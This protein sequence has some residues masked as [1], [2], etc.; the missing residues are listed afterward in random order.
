MKGESGFRRRQCKGQR[1]T[2]VAVRRGEISRHAQQAVERRSH[3]MPS[4]PSSGER[5]ACVAGRRE[6]CVGHSPR[7]VERGASGIR[8]VPSRG[9]RLLFAAGHREE[10][11]R[12]S[13]QALQWGASDILSR[14]CRNAE[15]AQLSIERRAS[16][17]LS[18]PPGVERP[19]LAAARGEGRVRLSPQAVQRTA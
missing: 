3:V 6:E 2:F 15:H 1:S 13:P 11:V 14:P 12:H 16:C 10:G 17:I 7:A 8:R 19:A 18:W 4:T 5:P 9:E